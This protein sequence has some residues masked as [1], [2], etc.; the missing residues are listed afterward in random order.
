MSQDKT[1][2]TATDHIFG[3]RSNQSCFVYRNAERKGVVYAVNPASNKS[4]QVFLSNCQDLVDY[5]RCELVPINDSFDANDPTLVRSQHNNL[6]DRVRLVRGRKKNGVYP[7]KYNH[8]FALRAVQVLH[9]S[10]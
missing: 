7:N 1:I 8:D 9:Q 3:M 2:F 6:I 4:V 10:Q 5:V